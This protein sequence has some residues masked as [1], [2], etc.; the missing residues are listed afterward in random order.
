ME[1]LLEAHDDQPAASHS[2]FQRLLYDFSMNHGPKSM[3]EWLAT[4][5]L[6]CVRTTH[7]TLEKFVL[8]P[9][10]HLVQSAAE[11][12]EA[13]YGNFCKLDLN[14]KGMCADAT[15]VK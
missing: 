14:K 3:R 1:H 2:E 6:H 7:H 9:N 5:N 10:S 11:A 8:F 4:T 12:C 13:L 15:H